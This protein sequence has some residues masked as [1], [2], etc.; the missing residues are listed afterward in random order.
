MNLM[1]PLLLVGMADTSGMSVSAKMPSAEMAKGASLEFQ[2]DIAFA[3]GL[4]ASEAGLPYP[5]LQIDVPK[6]VQL[7]GEEL[8][9][10]KQL[11]RNEF[12]MAP[13]ERVLESASTAIPFTLKRA[14]KDG[15]SLY[16]NV[17]G[18][19][20]DKDGNATFMRKRFQLPL[21]SGATATEVDA[22]DSSW[23]VD[24]Y[25]DIGDKA[26][27][28]TLPTADGEKVKLSD[29]RGQQNVVITTYRAHW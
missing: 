4:S 8:T 2:V 24:D 5:L 29:Y 18:Y 1:L 11:K 28:F 25:L 17:I 6:T 26:P 20:G 10:H 15:D 27:N 14:P 19:V 3:E 12:L 16:L 21:K 9:S 13:Y 23:T 22:A 7:G